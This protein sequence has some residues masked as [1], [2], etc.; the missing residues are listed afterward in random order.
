M[1]V[2]LL[3]ALLAGSS[4]R[5][6]VQSFRKMQVER[7]AREVY[8]SAQFARIQAIDSQRSCQVAL[9]PKTRSIAV[10][11]GARG[12]QQLV[13]NAYSR[14]YQ[15]SEE[16]N[17]ER[18]DITPTRPP[19]VMTQDE[20]PNTVITF[21]P[22]GSADG[23]V[24]QVGNGKTHWTVYISSA[25]GSARAELGVAKEDAPTMVIDLDKPSI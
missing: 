13:R 18:I 1:V 17:Y 19:E 7:A 14:P 9:D 12:G 8:L 20:A 15:F 25:T 10:M 3:I 6:S 21:R 5:G 4:I 11:A 24:V 16:V 22:D 2:T 23:A